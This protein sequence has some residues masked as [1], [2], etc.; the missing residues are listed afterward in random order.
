MVFHVDGT[1][2]GVRIHLEDADG[3]GLVLEILPLSDSVRISDAEE[4]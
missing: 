4:I 3:M 1:A 2:T